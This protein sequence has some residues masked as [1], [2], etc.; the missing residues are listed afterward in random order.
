MRERTFLWAIFI[1]TVVFFSLLNIHNDF[2]II[3]QNTGNV[4]DSG[5]VDLTVNLETNDTINI[6]SPADN[7]VEISATYNATYEVFLNATNDTAVTSWYY[8]LNDDLHGT[9]VYQ[10]ISFTPNTTFQAVRWQNTLTVIGVKN[11]TTNLTDAVTFNGSVVANTNPILSTLVDQEVC[12]GSKINYSYYA[13]DVDEHEN[14]LTSI[15]NPSYDLSSSPFDIASMGVTDYNRTNFYIFSPT[16]TSS[17]VGN[18]TLNISVLDGDGGIDQQNVTVEVLGISSSSCSTPSSSD[19]DAGGGGGGGGAGG[20]CTEIWACGSWDECVNVE[21][22][23]SFGILDEE[24]YNF[25]KELCVFEDYGE[26]IC[27]YQTKICDDV[28]E[29]NND[30]VAKLQPDSFQACYFVEDPSCS[31]GVTN[32]HDGSCELLIDCGGPCNACAT[33]SDGI[34]NQGEAGIDCGSPC[35]FS[36]DIEE[37]SDTSPFI[38]KFLLVLGFKSPITFE[39]LIFGGIILSGLMIL[40]LIIYWLLVYSRVKILLGKIHYKKNRRR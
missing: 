38:S 25:A 9:L 29:C 39:K 13:E 10:N 6:T 3:S 19:G 32:C 26:E 17:H 36:C 22:A 15:V 12:E 24:G 30:Y 16:L 31:D 23:L 2:A 21:D 7:G 11:S 5:F 35:A 1:L 37:P 4:V 28:N 8:S 33:C 20:S 34:Q 40:L 14:T 18:H 27:G